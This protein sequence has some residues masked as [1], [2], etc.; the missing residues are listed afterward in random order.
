MCQASLEV[1]IQILVLQLPGDQTLSF[2]RLKVEASTSSALST[3]TILRSLKLVVPY[4]S[5]VHHSQT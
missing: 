1:Q 3:L 5:H 2:E 4:L